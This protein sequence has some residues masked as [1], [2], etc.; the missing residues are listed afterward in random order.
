MKTALVTTT[1]RPPRVLELMRKYDPDVRFFVAGDENSSEECVNFCTHDLENTQYLF[2]K[3]QQQYLCSKL[4]GW[5][6]IQRRNIAVLEALKWGA[7][8]IVSWDDDNLPINDSYFWDFE[9]KFEFLH[10]GFQVSTRNRWVNQY[11]ASVKHRGFPVD[12]PISK[13]IISTV[14]DA[15]VGV[16]AGLCLGDPDIDAYTR[17]ANPQCISYSDLISTN[18]YVVAPDNRCVFNTQN[19]AY[20]RQFAPA[21]FCVPGLGR[22]DDIIASLLTQRVMR[23]AGY[24]VHIGQPFT[25]QERNPHDLLID[26]KDEI[27]GMEHLMGIAEFIEHMPTLLGP[28]EPIV[29]G[30]CRNFW[31]GCGDLPEIS[32][33]AGLAF[34]DDCEKVMG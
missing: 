10:R 25:Y 11:G 5:N 13:P 15:K 18:G 22:H 28:I 1:I 7:E 6:C 26:L 31:G 8:V 14:V 34:L 23:D 19:T 16:A 3:D 29:R 17:M 9:R 4:I 27:W 30:M 21:M 2:V 32:R 24:Q 20:L 12:V 33:E